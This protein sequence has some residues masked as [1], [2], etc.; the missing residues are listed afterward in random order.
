MCFPQLIFCSPCESPKAL[1]V[2]FGVF[3]GSLRSTGAC[4]K[5]FVVKYIFPVS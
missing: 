2:A 4:H 3:F 1:A 5:D